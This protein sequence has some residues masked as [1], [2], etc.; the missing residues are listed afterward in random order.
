VPKIKG[1]CQQCGEEIEFFPSQAR[2][3]CSL[4]CRSQYAAEHG[5]MPT[6]PRTGTYVPCAICGEPVWRMKSEKSKRFCSRDCA[7]AGNRNGDEKECEG[8]GS[9]FYVV[10]SAPS[11]FCTRECYESH[12]Q[13]RSSVGRMHNGRHV[14]RDWSGYLRIWEPDHPSSMQ[15][16]VLEH[17]WIVEQALGRYLATDEHVHHL[18]GVK[19]D[20]RPENL[21]LLDAQAHRLLTATEIKEQRASDA[22]EL[23]EYRR[24]FGP[25]T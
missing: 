22:T 5:P 16:R 13:V 9:L 21:Q 17:R 2:R 11:R 12:R 23:T 20:N 18:N 14:I 8:C 19:D 1:K 4:S 24:R 3:Y 15:G 7:T 10:P 6:K 25:L